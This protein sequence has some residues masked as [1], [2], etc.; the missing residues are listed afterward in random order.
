M[1]TVFL[2]TC[3]S[4]ATRSDEMLI[5]GRSIVIKANEQPIPE[6]FTFLTA[7]AGDLAALKFINQDISDADY[8]KNVERIMC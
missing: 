6:N 5:A 1:V 8:R 7:A 2:D 4:G 3:Y